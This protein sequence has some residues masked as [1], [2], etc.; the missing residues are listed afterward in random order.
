MSLSDLPAGQ[1]IADTNDEIRIDTFV[2]DVDSASAAVTPTMRVRD[3]RVEFVNGTNVQEL[4]VYGS[5]T[6]DNNYSALR[7]S[8]SPAIASITASEVTAGSTASLP[9][10]FNSENQ[11]GCNVG[12]AYFI[13]EGTQTLVQNTLVRIGDLDEIENATFFTINSVTEA[14]TLSA[15]DVNLSSFSIRMPLLPT[16]DPTTAGQVWNDNGTLKISA[17]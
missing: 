1:S 11:V 9:L 12:D 2:I 7:L 17:G 10:A 4:R 6:D 8:A 13:L 3:N 5:Y 14:V 16:S 15:G